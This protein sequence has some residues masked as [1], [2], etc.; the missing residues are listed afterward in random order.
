MRQDR[1]QGHSSR[2]VV[3][4]KKEDHENENENDAWIGATGVRTGC[5]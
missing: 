1:W 3:H 2:K 4:S 5:R